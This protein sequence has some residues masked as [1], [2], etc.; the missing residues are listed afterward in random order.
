MNEI[1]IDWL[2]EDMIY[3]RYIVYLLI[4]FTVITGILIGLKI[5]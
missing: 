2:N 1:L 4:I 5:S 3:N